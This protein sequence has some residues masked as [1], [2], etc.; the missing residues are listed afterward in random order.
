[1]VLEGGFNLAVS[2]G[3]VVVTGT[4]EVFSFSVSHNKL[5]LFLV[6]D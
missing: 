3:I 1:V 5:L 2:S 4:K 6:V